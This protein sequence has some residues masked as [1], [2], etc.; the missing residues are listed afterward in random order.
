MSAVTTVS[1]GTSVAPSGGWETTILGACATGAAAV[2]AAG[3]MRRLIAWTYPRPR[4]H[5]QKV[6]ARSVS[7]SRDRRARGIARV[8]GEL[9][10]RA[11]VSIS[12]VIWFYSRA[13]VSRARPDGHL[14]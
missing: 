1:S 12:R 7:T 5:Q 8:R 13:R 4:A 2:A 10:A 3:K 14:R 9:V 6:V 11:G